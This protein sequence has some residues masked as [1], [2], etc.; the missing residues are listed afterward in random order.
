MPPVIRIENLSKSYRIQHG[1]A[2]GQYR[3][4]RETITA[5]PP[6]RCTACVGRATAGS[7][8]SGP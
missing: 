7:R 4:L 8:S 1:A 6:R 2:R 3:T 5:W